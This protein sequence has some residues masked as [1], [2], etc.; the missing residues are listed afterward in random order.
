M[1]VGDGRVLGID[2]MV[3]EGAGSAMGAAML[4]G[5]AAGLFKD[6]EEAR[7]RCRGKEHVMRTMLPEVASRPAVQPV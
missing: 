5:V 4:G 6:L 1:A 7:K 2:A 3:V